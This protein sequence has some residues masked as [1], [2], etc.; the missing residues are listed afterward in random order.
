MIKDQRIIHSNQQSV[1]CAFEEVV[2]EMCSPS[3]CIQFLESLAQFMGD[4]IL[5]AK[6]TARKS[7]ALDAFENNPD[8]ASSF[9]LQTEEK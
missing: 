5:L 7:T 8:A 3:A 2:F 6:P 1:M 4:P 9:V